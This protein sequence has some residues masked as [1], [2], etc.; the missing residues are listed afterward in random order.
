M[1]IKPPNATPFDFNLNYEITLYLN[2]NSYFKIPIELK[3]CIAAFA[4]IEGLSSKDHFGI[5][6]NLKPF[7]EFFI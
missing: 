3:F 4:H 1:E 2:L 5:K 7:L 6:K